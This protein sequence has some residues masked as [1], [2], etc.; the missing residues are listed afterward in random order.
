MSII[1]SLPKAILEFCLSPLH[2]NASAASLRQCS[3]KL[4]SIGRS[5]VW[6]QPVRLDTFNPSNTSGC[7]RILTIGS[8][9]RKFENRRSRP[10][11]RIRYDRNRHKR[12]LQSD[13]L[14]LQSLFNFKKLTHVIITNHAI[15]HLSLPKT[16]TILEIHSLYRLRSLYSHRTDSIF[17]NVSES[18]Y[19]VRHLILHNFGWRKNE[20]EFIEQ[21][22]N[23]EHLELVRPFGNVSFNP[24]T[25]RL[26]IID[27]VSIDTSA[28]IT[29]KSVYEKEKIP[30]IGE[31]T[32]ERI[33]GQDE[34]IIGQD[35][36]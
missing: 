25:H 16:V 19:T 33:I 20:I 17:K 3:R 21:F 2:D 35:F 23:L 29:I 11:K 27:Y 8:I 36:D 18:L 13:D 24:M 9:Y 6:N 28:N 14:K 7:P 30:L 26:N 1:E 15:L 12:I 22:K 32:H 31:W 10:Q 4:H 5:H 34:R